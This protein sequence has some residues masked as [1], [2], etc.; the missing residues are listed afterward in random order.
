MLRRLWNRACKHLSPPLA[1]PSSPV[2]RCALDSLACVGVA[3]ARAGGAHSSSFTTNATERPDANVLR[4]YRELLSLLR[5]LP[6]EQR[7]A[8]RLEART[9]IQSHAREAS[10]SARSDQLK[11]LWARISFLRVVRMKRTVICDCLCSFTTSHAVIRHQTLPRRPGDRARGSGTFVLRG[12]QL[13]EE[14]AST[15]GVRVA[16]GVLDM[17]EARQRHAS[18]LKRQHF[19]R[20]PSR[21]EPF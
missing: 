15:L 14:E 20:T 18:L 21:T 7:E 8:A 19:G 11:L 2:R 3:T 16:K 17:G 5:R 12:G 1:G 4:A 9:A 6:R 13:V 10:E